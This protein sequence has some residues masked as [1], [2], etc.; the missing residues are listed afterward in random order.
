MQLLLILVNYSIKG[1]K[2]DIQLNVEIVNVR[3]FNI[4][5]IIK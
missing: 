1:V 5:K 3:Y 4:D 2:W